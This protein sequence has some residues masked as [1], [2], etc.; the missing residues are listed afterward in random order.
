[1]TKL[2]ENNETVDHTRRGLL[3]K[4]GKYAALAPVSTLLVT[5]SARASG[6]GGTFTFNGITVT[7]R[8]QCGSA[9][10][11]NNA[12]QAACRAYFDSL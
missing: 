2:I 11:G 7:A 5:K 8:N 9:F 6:S 12:V 1:M 4:G 3:I 10:S